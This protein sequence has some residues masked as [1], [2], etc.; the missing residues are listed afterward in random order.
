MVAPCGR[1][2]WSIVLRDAAH[3]WVVTR[4]RLRLGLDA[5]PDAPLINERLWLERHADVLFDTDAQKRLIA[6]NEPDSSMAPPRLFLARGR[7]MA[8]TRFHVDVPSAVV[9]QVG[10]T[11]DALPPWD[12]GPPDPMIY[13]PLRRALAESGQVADEWLGPAFRFPVFREHRPM[14]DVLLIDEATAHLLDRHFP[15][16]RSILG[17]RS[18]VL[19]LV[20]DGA[21]VS[22]CYSARRRPD[23]AEAGVD[24]DEA[25]RGAGLAVAVVQAWAR[26]IESA[27]MTPLYSTSWG[28]SASLRVATKLGLAYADTFSLT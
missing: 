17:W 16:T 19:G 10:L 23:A 5:A 11:V 8:I 13:Q 4:H 26:A 2:R 27:G 7:A 21:V 12:G 25:Y 6:V 9:A 14:D 20:R 28:N 1:R 15:Y 3:T 18:P 22:V 24:T